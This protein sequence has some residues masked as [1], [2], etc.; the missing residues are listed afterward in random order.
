MKSIIRLAWINTELLGGIG[1]ALSERGLLRLRM[2]QPSRE[3]F[4]ALNQSY[5]KGEYRYEASGTRE[6]LEQLRAYLAQELKVFSAPIDW[7][8]YT[9]FQQ[10]VLQ[11]TA[12]IP[13]GETRSYGNLA[14]A[15]G[16]PGAA[17]A[18]GQAEKN[19]QV[20][21]IIP[22]HRVIGSSGALVGYGGSEDTSLKQKL[23]D[24]ERAGL[25]QARG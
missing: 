17:R 3:A 21:L 14:A 25:K 16:K 6:I 10:A 8:G 22:C 13:Y 9:A 1:V 5:G 20:P 24:F 15:V 11:Q 23:L 18:V 19:N 2:F 4:L 7:S 12:R